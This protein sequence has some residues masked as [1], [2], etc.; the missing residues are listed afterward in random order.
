MTN[1]LV[2]VRVR[3]CPDGTHNGEGDWVAL[4]PRLSLEGGLAA[5]QVVREA[6]SI[7]DEAE[8]GEAIQRRWIMAFV[9]YGAKDW[10]LHEN[11]ED[12]PFSPE[13]LMQDY[14]IA[15]EVADKAADLYSEVVL[16]PF[17]ERQRKRSP[18]GPTGA[19]TSKARRQTRKPSGPSSPVT[20]ADS[21]P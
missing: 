12:I 16:R 6:A 13:A 2:I 18:T 21:A 11:G 1:D 7:A 8:R 4:A 15:R 10:N 19:T 14:A 20:T 9:R 17:L 3:D 5:E